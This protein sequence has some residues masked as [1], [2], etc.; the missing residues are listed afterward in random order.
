MPASQCTHSIRQPC[1]CSLTVARKVSWSACLQYGALLLVDPEEETYPEEVSKLAADVAVKGLGLI[2]IGE[3]YNV[4]TMVKMRFFDDN[5]RSW[6]TPA[7]GAALNPQ[8]L[9]RACLYLGCLEESSCIAVICAGIMHSALQPDISTTR[10][11]HGN[12]NM[13]CAGICC[14]EAC[15]YWLPGS[16]C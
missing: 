8:P 10:C 12:V 15:R 1:I 7:T 9:L 6:W 5:T 4:D 3:W 16:G 13:C 14:L 11:R 2:V